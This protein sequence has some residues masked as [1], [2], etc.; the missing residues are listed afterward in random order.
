V[1]WVTQAPVSPNDLCFGPDGFLYFT[2]P[3]HRPWEDGRLWRCEVETGDAG[4]LTSVSWSPNGIAFGLENDAVYARI[5]K[6]LRGNSLAAQRGLRAARGFRQAPYGCPDGLVFD[7]DGNPCRR[8]VYLDGG[9]GE[10]QLYDSTGRVLDGRRPAH[11]RKACSALLFCPTVVRTFENKWRQNKEA[12]S[13]LGTAPTPTKRGLHALLLQVP[14]VRWT[15]RYEARLHEPSGGSTRAWSGPS[16]QRRRRIRL[17]PLRPIKRI[18]RVH[19]VDP[20]IPVAR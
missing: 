4:L 16:F 19:G 11:G 17:A 13:G 9:P 1:S 18:R 12:R 20:R 8:R 10:L 7:V 14:Q 3:T 15:Q 5:D 2:D 6:R